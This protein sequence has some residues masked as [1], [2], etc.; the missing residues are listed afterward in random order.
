MIESLPD[1]SHLRYCGEPVEWRRAAF[2]TSGWRLLPVSAGPMSTNYLAL[3]QRGS[4]GVFGGAFES[5]DSSENVGGDDFEHESVSAVAMEVLRRL[6]VF[7]VL[8]RVEAPTSDDHVFVLSPE[9]LALASAVAQRRGQSLDDLLTSVIESKVVSIAVVD[10]RDDP[11]IRRLH[12][13][14]AESWRKE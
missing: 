14:L 13:N 2:S 1:V 8:T 4:D 12:I 9:L 6:L 10:Y 5:A 7:N 11:E 3:V